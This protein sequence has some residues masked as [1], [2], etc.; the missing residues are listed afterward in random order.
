MRIHL[1]RI[2]LRAVFYIYFCTS[3][4]ICALKPDIVPFVHSR[5]PL[6]RA[7]SLPSIG[8]AAVSIRIPEPTPAS[9]ATAV[10]QQDSWT[11][12]TKIPES[13]M[14]IIHPCTTVCQRAC[15]PCKSVGIC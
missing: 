13:T 3:V 1:V 8:T 4:Y 5:L 11:S 10:F 7:C 9:H 15:A 6:V 14:Y 2:Q 12:W